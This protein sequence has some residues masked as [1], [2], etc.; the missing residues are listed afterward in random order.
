MMRRFWKTVAVDPK[1]DG[2]LLWSSRGMR[3]L[4]LVWSRPVW[5]A[6]R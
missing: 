2:A 3:E 6:A 1:E 5:C 4:M